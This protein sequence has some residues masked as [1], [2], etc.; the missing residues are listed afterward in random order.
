MQRGEGLGM[1]GV[2]GADGGHWKWS[3]HH[4]EY[5]RQPSWAPLSR[6]AKANELNIHF[7]STGEHVFQWPRG[8]CVQLFMSLCLGCLC[9]GCCPLWIYPVTASTKQHTQ[10]RT[11]WHLSERQT[12]GK[13]YIL[14]SPFPL[15]HFL[16]YT[17]LCIYLKK[18]SNKTF[19]HSYL[20]K[21]SDIMG[22]LAVQFRKEKWFF[23]FLPSG[24]Y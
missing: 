19:L 9:L 13:F 8:W 3:R 2:S 4:G 6:T 14:L 10:V 18:K 16:T 1:V 15:Q 11:Q 22:L 21:E 12:L 5:P 23:H 17:T 20:F 24:G 7:K